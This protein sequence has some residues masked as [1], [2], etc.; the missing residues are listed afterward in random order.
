[1]PPGLFKT[2]RTDATLVTDA[3]GAGGAANRSHVLATWSNVGA[4]KISRCF[5]AVHTLVNFLFTLASACLKCTKASLSLS[6]KRA[7]ILRPKSE[8][9][10]L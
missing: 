2:S 8:T 4:G 1:M 7:R 9:A 3:I 6:A 10:F 5:Q